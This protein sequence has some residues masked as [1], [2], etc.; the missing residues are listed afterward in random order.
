[1][2][3]GGSA[4]VIGGFVGHGPTICNLLVH[5]FR[6]V[7]AFLLTLK[8]RRGAELACLFLKPAA[9]QGGVVVSVCLLSLVIVTAASTPQY[10]QT[11]I[12][13]SRS[14]HAQ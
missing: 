3:Y 12:V 8:D 4:S 2:L 9:F 5:G 7:R 11:A 1:M 10:P 13:F 14:L 6:N